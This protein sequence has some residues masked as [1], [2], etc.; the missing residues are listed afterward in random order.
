MPVGSTLIT[1]ASFYTNFISRIGRWVAL[2]PTTKT[3]G[4]IDGSETITASES[5]ATFILA[6][7]LRKQQ[8]WQFDKAGM[9]EGGDAYLISRPSDSVAMDKFVY[10]NGV[11]VVIS[12]IDGDATTISI[13]TSA[14]HGLSAGDKIYIASTTNYNAIYTVATT[15]TTVTLTIANTS[16]NLAAETSGVLVRDWE[17]YRVKEH[18]IRSGKFGDAAEQSYSYSNLFIINDDVA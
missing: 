18:V 15:P 12:A 17:I 7:F 16:H 2:V 14:A 9:I 5:T 3:F 6:A 10:A 11:E 4:N 8:K 1:S 13:T